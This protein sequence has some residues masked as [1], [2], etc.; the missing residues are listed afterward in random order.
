MWF[1]DT[2]LRIEPNPQVSYLNFCLAAICQ[3]CNLS[4][5]SFRLA[6]FF[7]PQI[8]SAL[9]S[10]FF[11]S[12][13]SPFITNMTSKT[14]FLDGRWL[15]SESHITYQNFKHWEAAMRQSHEMAQTQADGQQLRQVSM[16]RP[17]SP[18][19]TPQSSSE[20]ESQF[21][22]E[23][24]PEALMF[25]L[26]RNRPALDALRRTRK[27]RYRHNLKFLATSFPLADE[28]AKKDKEVKKEAAKKAEKAQGLT[29]AE[30]LAQKEL[31]KKKQVEKTV[32]ELKYIREMKAA[33]VKAAA[34]ERLKEKEA[35]NGTPGKETEKVTAKSA[36]ETAGK[37]VE[38]TARKRA[39][40]TGKSMEKVMQ[41]SA[42]LMPPN[43][44][45]KTAPKTAGKRAEKEAQQSFCPMPP[46]IFAIKAPKR[47][48]KSTEESDEEDSE[49]TVKRAK[50][51]APETVEETAPKSTGSTT[52]RKSG[53]KSLYAKMM[54]KMK[55]W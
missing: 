12:S 4:S 38:T 40:K 41:S 2:Y 49:K 18:A 9:K 3:T 7:N 5:N 19:F 39:E 30:I 47:A 33:K 8:V 32:E 53:K 43:V 46:N 51:T 16:W 24:E 14:A 28:Q 10:I 42:S 1:T 6:I 31:A 20:N 50:K 25:R 55:R 36:K 26:A 52:A 21:A 34:S 15:P 37:K 11:P 44:F 54:P 22:Y 23:V 17:A 35:K 45:A 48:A 13:E 27:M 29:S